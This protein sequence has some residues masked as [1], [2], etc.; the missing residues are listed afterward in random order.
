MSERL[1][2]RSSPTQF[3]VA[4]QPRPAKEISPT[5]IC[6]CQR[7]LQASVP[8]CPTWATQPQG[9]PPPAAQL[10]AVADAQYRN[11]LQ[12]TQSQG[13]LRPQL[14]RVPHRA[15]HL[16]PVSSAAQAPLPGGL[17]LGYATQPGASANGSATACKRSRKRDRGDRWYDRC[18]YA[19]HKVTK[20]KHDN[21]DILI[22]IIKVK[23]SVEFILNT[24]PECRTRADLI[25]IRRDLQGILNDY[26][27]EV[28]FACPHLA[29]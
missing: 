6:R 18:R 23:S 28:A 3:A 27:R 1:W 24:P 13:L 4:T 9:H 11:W 10:S 29:P 19:R 15:L 2:A 12:K 5:T 26:P 20:L 25:A 8:G 22:R 21:Q 16:A 17:Q 7:E 14:Q